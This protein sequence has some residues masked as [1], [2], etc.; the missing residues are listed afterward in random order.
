MKGALNRRYTLS[1]VGMYRFPVWRGADPP[2]WRRLV[3][4]YSA[5]RENTGIEVV[6]QSL[7][8]DGQTFATL[9]LHDAEINTGMALRALESGAMWRVRGVGFI[10]VA[11]HAAGLRLV[12]LEPLGDG[13][14]LH[15]GQRL[16]VQR[17]EAA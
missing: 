2:R 16:V 17:P 14:R 8:R 12:L 9:R 11:A 7:Y 6:H 10:P 15:K 4:P 1:R 13:Q 5:R 3:R